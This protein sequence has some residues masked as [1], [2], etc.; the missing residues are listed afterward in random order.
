MWYRRSFTVPSAWNGRRTLP[1]FGAVDQQATVHADGSQADAH[2]GGYAA[3]Q[4]DITPYL[5][6]GS[7]E[8]IAVSTTQSWPD[9][10]AARRLRR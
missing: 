10:I 4:S 9:R 7:N 5:R 6:A 8:I 1:N 2:T 3:F